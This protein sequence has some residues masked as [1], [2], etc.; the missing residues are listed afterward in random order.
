MIFLKNN[1]WRGIMPFR[2]TKERTETLSIRPRTG[3]P[4]P[5]PYYAWLYPPGYGK[6]KGSYTEKIR[7]EL[8]KWM[9]E[10]NGGW[11]NPVTFYYRL[12]RKKVIIV[13]GYYPFIRH[14]PGRGFE[15]LI[16]QPYIDGI[17]CR[18]L[19][20]IYNIKRIIRKQTIAGLLPLPGQEVMNLDA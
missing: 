13:T 14:T 17:K 2:R 10:K 19:A 8:W 18:G 11:A 5:A 15:L 6:A 12:S 20:T 4:C 16:S 3:E 9:D 1:R 7:Q